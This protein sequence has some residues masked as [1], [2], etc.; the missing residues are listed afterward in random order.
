[1]PTK[2]F[3]FYRDPSSSTLSKTFLRSGVASFHFGRFSEA[4]NCFVE[5]QKLGEE[6]IKKLKADQCRIEIGDTQTS[7]SRHLCQLGL[8]IAQ[9]LTLLI[10]F[11]CS[12]R[13]QSYFNQ[14]RDTVGEGGRCS[15]GRLLGET[16]DHRCLEELFQLQ[17]QEV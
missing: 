8:S 17:L 10:L 9:N 5:G 14:Y 4:L 3:K 11:S 7:L 13:I 1:M 2:A 16:E 15:L 12:I 6:R